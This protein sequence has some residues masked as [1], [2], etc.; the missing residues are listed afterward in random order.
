MLIDEA[1]DV[2]DE[3]ASGRY[4]YHSSPLL[5]A[6]KTLADELRK[7]KDEYLESQIN[8]LLRDG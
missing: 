5:E 2:I 3:Y 8:E 1:L 4:R 7:P 6:A